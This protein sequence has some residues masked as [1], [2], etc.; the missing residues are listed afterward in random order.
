[1]SEVWEAFRLSVNEKD[2]LAAFLRDVPLARLER[3]RRGLSLL[4]IGPD[5]GQLTLR[6]CEPFSRITMV[7]ADSRSR[8]RLRGNL[9]RHGRRTP[10]FAEC[11]VIPARFP[12]NGLGRRAYDLTL[13]SHVLYFIPRDQWTQSILAAYET[14]RP[15]GM[16]VATYVCDEGAMAEL[17]AGF[18]GSPPRFREFEDSCRRALPQAQIE[19]YRMSNVMCALDEDA[20]A[21]FFGFLMTDYQAAASAQEAKQYARRFRRPNGAYVWEKTDGALV[22][23]RPKDS[24]A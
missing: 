18:G 16:L 24:P 15:G 20:I 11:R 21:H 3:R 12:C 2:M 5:D 13:M 22:I 9:R 4:D 23:T 6:I 1:L 17:I 7:E 19:I 8:A 14:L 10:D